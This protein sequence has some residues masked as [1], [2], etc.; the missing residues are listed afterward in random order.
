[1]STRFS[2]LE[3]GSGDAFLLEDSDNNWNCLFDA[4]GSKSKIVSLLKNKKRRI[5]KI[6]L[7]ICSH[8]DGDHANG[9]IGLL[10]EPDID[11]DEIWLPYWWSSILQYAVEQDIDWYEVEK[12]TSR[13]NDKSIKDYNPKSMF[14]ANHEPLSDEA[15]GRVLSRLAERHLMNYM[16]IPLTPYRSCYG[17]AYDIAY[18]MID[19]LAHDP[20]CIPNHYV[21]HRLS[22]RLAHR[23]AQD[24]ARFVANRVARQ[25]TDYDADD[26]AD[27]VAHFV[28]HYVAYYIYP[29]H[30][31][32]YDID[33]LYEQIVK[34]LT[35]D[36]FNQLVTTNSGNNIR[37]ML[38]NIM[39]IAV[40]AYKRGCKIKWFEPTKDCTRFPIPKTNFIALNSNL[41]REV[42]IL[43]DTIAL[44]FALRLTVENEYSLAFEYLNEDRV[45]IVR[46]SADS[47][48]ECGSLPYDKSIIITAPHH[49][50]E[51]NA[52]VYDA[53]DPN[54]QENII[55]VR[56]DALNKTQGRPCSDFKLRKNKY[57]LA[58]K[59]RIRNKKI[60][61]CF[62]Y[63]ILIRKW[64]SISGY[65][66]IC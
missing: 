62:E 31:R 44:A 19:R 28:A 56:S 3:I 50:S 46:F 25:G 4:G 1:M 34:F 45:P 24:T 55:W 58:C 7:A 39:E 30:R 5:K 41:K 36:P 15:F 64:K 65:Q 14:S 61:V 51:A 9:F 37:I 27:D 43:R 63:D 17:L 66:C 8:N 33:D 16:E 13:I 22:H 54:N 59:N 10:K 23:I 2:A 38:N 6:N 52:N 47:D 20:D 11:I 32:H 21:A 29:E 48:C 60:E 57:C 49:G 35:S 12:I 18:N 53:I 40:L 26:V 42:Q